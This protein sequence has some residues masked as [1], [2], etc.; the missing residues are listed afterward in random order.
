[1]KSYLAALAL[2]ATFAQPAAATTFPS[3]TTIYVVSGVL[4]NGGD[5]DTGLATTIV[6]S[7]VSGVTTNIRLLLL[8]SAGAVLA[9]ENRINVVH[10]ATIQQ[11]THHTA[12]YDNE[13]SF[14][15]G[16][17]N[18]GVINIESLQSGVFCTAHVVDASSDLVPNGLDLHM[19]RVNPHPGTVE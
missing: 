15:S 2:A 7:N 13:E 3:L 19:V 18:A 14:D 17:V 4:D 16:T 5:S 11:S 1:M 12:L 9:T 8:N 10:G 6:C